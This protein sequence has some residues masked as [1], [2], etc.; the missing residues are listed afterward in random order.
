M[1]RFFVV[2]ACFSPATPF[3]PALRSGR[4]TFQRPSPNRKFVAVKQSIGK[5]RDPDAIAK[6]TNDLFNAVCWSRCEADLER[7][8]RDGGDVNAKSEVEGGRTPLMCASQKSC[9]TLAEKMVTMLLEAGAKPNIRDDSPH[10]WTALFY[11]ACWGHAQVARLLVK[12]GANPLLQCTEGKTPIQ[13]ALQSGY[14]EV[15]YAIQQA[16]K[17]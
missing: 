5:R 9:S 4:R 12:A 17:S 14:S 13:I 15:I 2:S 10:K 7:A 11:A 3:F 1:L 6:A 16:S 8:I